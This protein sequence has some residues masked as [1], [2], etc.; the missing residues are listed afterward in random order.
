VRAAALL[1]AAGAAQAQPVEPLAPEDFLGLAEG[2]TLTFAEIGRGADFGTEEFLGRGRTRYVMADGTC[3]LG[4]V[5][6]RG[7]AVCFA[8]PVSE[9]ESCWWMFRQG[10]RILARSAG[11]AGGAIVEVVGISDKPVIC[12]AVPSV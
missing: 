3:T 10:E 6:V 1:L 8:Y 12:E 4:V 9:G 2:R 5:T 11:V 7:P